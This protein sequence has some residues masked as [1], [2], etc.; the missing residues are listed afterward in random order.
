MEKGLIGSGRKTVLEVES[1]KKRPFLLMIL[2]LLGACAPAGALNGKR[3]RGA[4]WE[5]QSYKGESIL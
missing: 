5:I 4:S 1:M 2:V 3:G